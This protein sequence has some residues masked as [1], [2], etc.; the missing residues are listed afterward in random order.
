MMHEQRE[1]ERVRFQSFLR[2]VSFLFQNDILHFHTILLTVDT[3]N[4]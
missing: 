4:N 3:F 1:R 2:L